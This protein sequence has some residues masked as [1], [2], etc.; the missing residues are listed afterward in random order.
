[1]TVPKIKILWYWLT[2]GP[3][4]FARMRALSRAQ[5]ID[6]TVVEASASDDH[7]WVRKEQ[8]DAL[9][10]TTL[11]TEPKSTRIMRE[12][13]PAFARILNET[14]PDIV[15]GPGYFE[16]YTLDAIFDYRKSNPNCLALLWSETTA[17]DHPRTQIKEALKRLV[18]A[19]FDGALVAGSLHAS[20]LRLLGMSDADVQI[21]GNCVD[22]DF[23]SGKADEVRQAVR[24]VTLPR[25]FFLFVGRMLPEKNIAG[26]LDAYNLY[27][28]R[29]GSGAWD[30]VLVGSGPEASPLKERV[31]AEN[32]DGANFAGLVQLE[33]LPHYYANAGCFVLP[34]M[35]EPWGLVVNEAMA[36]GI[37]VLV[38]NRCGCG[39]DLV[40]DGKN[41]FVFDPLNT[42]ALADLLF[43]MSHG[44]A[45]PDAMG[46]VSREMITAYTPALF[47]QRAAQHISSLRERK[48]GKSRSFSATHGLMRVALRGLGAMTA[49]GERLPAR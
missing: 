43:R 1:M 45:S 3:Y 48:A 7:G 39:P 27:R 23:F 20:Y 4:H 10:L 35:S 17:V 37:P 9:Q 6:L 12:T 15:V 47:A 33:E 30:L 31:K 11:S 49:V 46:K 22:N 19:A 25:D 26:L 38:S 42:Q 14:R 21:V 29:V 24:S 2:M 40:R 44:D 36:S 18:V 5:G 13:K 8:A 16:K 34:S 28:Q 41:G 32:I